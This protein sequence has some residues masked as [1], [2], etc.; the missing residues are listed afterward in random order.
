M[1]LLFFYRMNCF[2]F[3]TTFFLLSH[4]RYINILIHFERHPAKNL[5]WNGIVNWCNFYRN[6]LNKM[7]ATRNYRWKILWCFTPI[8]VTV[9]C[10]EMRAIL[11]ST[12][13]WTFFIFVASRIYCQRM[14]AVAAADAAALSCCCFVSIVSSDTHRSMINNWTA[15]NLLLL[16]F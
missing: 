10:E 3:M 9:V 2:F 16:C 13:T 7:I 12:W 1:D 15:F 4:S 6:K 11:V 5:R 8:L 14:T